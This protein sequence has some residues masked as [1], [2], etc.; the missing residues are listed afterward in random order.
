M[1]VLFCGLLNA[2]VVDAS[3]TADIWQSFATLC[4]PGPDADER[5][6]GARLVQS[7]VTVIGVLFM[8]AVIGF[9]VD[10]IR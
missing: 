10:A 5:N 2:L 4:D 1:L 3:G 7:L 6:F 8:S 9:V